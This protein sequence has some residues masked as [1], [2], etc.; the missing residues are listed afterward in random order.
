M[1]N[2]FKI[3]NNNTNCMFRT[4]ATFLSWILCEKIYILQTIEVE[5][6]LGV[7]CCINKI[8]VKYLIVR[9]FGRQ[10]CKSIF[11]FLH[12]ESNLRHVHR[13]SV[14]FISFFL[15]INILKERIIKVEGKFD[16]VRDCWV[17]PDFLNVFPSSTSF[18]RQKLSWFLVVLTLRVSVFNLIYGWVRVCNPIDPVSRLQFVV[19]LLC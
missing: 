1:E 19:L 6:F 15:F 16:R 2:P 18:S 14:Q 11:F 5:R 17:S 4:I 12:W 10:R 7:Y 9:V 3:N 8:K 13:I